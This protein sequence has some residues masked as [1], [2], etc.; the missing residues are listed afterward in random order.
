VPTPSPL[1]RLP[2]PTLKRLLARPDVLV[3]LAAAAV[4][5]GLWGV[6]EGLDTVL[7][8]GPDSVERALLLALQSPERGPVGPRWLEVLA[9]DYTALGSVGVL[10][11][12]T[13]G[14]S[15]YLWLRRRGPVA[16][17]LLAT[18]GGGL[19]LSTLLKLGVDRSRPAAHLHASHVYSPSF[20]SGH[21]MMAAVTY[22]TLGLLLAH[23][24]RR[25]AV[26]RYVLSGALLVTATVGATRVYLGIHWP[27]DVLA[28]WTVG[29]VWALACWLGVLWKRRG[30]A[31][32]NESSA[33]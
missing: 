17:Y 32:Q 24:H 6:V 30:S 1:P 5:G 13:V 4:A 27:T 11:L 3:L 2:R 14:V 20:P 15:G 26:Q 8:G 31:P 9:R 19:V 21:A 23:V 28:G 7:D 16:A 22:L 12:L 18:V 10:T 33:L 29:T 25:N